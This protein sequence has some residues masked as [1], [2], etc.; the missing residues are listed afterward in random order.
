MTDHSTDLVERT[1]VGA[2]S[3][4]RGVAAGESH[5]ITP[6]QY[7][8][9]AVVLAI[10]TAVEVAISYVEDLDTDL[11]IIVLLGLAAV[12]FFLVASWFMHLKFDKPIFK[13]IFLVGTTMAVLLFFVVL[14]T[15]SVFSE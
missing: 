8:M 11:V 15:F 4:G 2:A 6:R 7:V 12:K 14:L 13:R 10:V 9:V 5:H 3:E 1:E